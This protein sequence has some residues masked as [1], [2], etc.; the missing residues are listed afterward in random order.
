M[1]VG[2]CW[3]SHE[4]KNLEHGGR[5][6]YAGSPSFSGLGLEEGQVPTFWLPLYCDKTLAQRIRGKLCSPTSEE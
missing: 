2:G 1:A 3:H 6:I 5:M 4:F